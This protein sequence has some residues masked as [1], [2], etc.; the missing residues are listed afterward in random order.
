M[1]GQVK[2]EVLTRFGELGL[3]IADGELRFDPGL[4]RAREFTSGPRPFRFLDVHGQWQELTVPVSGL[5]FTWCQV[6]VVY[7]LR[8]DGRLT[9]TVTRHDGSIEELPQASL[10]AYLSSELFRRSGHV[11][12]ISLDV[13]GE[14]LLGP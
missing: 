12:Q 13:P 4:L 5:A 3:R 14:A 6:P 7:R 11:R 1:T 9:L 8:G 10:P 2:E